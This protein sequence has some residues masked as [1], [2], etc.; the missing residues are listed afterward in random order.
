MSPSTTTAT[1]TVRMMAAAACELSLPSLFYIITDAV[2]GAVPMPIF[3][4]TVLISQPT[5][6]GASTVGVRTTCVLIA[7]SCTRTARSPARAI[8]A[9]RKATVGTSARPSLR[10]SA[11]CAERRVSRR[12][13]ALISAF[14]LPD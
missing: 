14:R 12:L 6:V 13:P 3:R 7:T 9:E 10:I 8:N 1:R 11:M 5:P 2:L 4:R